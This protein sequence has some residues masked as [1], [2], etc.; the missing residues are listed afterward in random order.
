MLLSFGD[1]R[2]STLRSFH[3]AFAL[4][5]SVATPLHAQ[6]LYGPDQFGAVDL[7][8]RQSTSATS[9][10][11]TLGAKQDRFEPIA[12]FPPDDPVRVLGKAVGRLDIL[13]AEP[14]GNRGVANCTTTLIDRDKILTNYHCVP[15]LDG[16]VIEKILVR[17]GYLDFGSTTSKAFAVDV[18]PIEANKDLDYAI[19]H[20]AGDPGG[21]FGIAPLK[22]R[23]ATANERLFI[24]RHPA[25]Q[26]RRLTRAFCRADPKLAIDQTQLRHQCDTLPGSSGALIFAQRD[27][28]LVG[29]HH[30]GGLAA[31]D[32]SSFNQAIDAIALGHGS[33]EFAR[34]CCDAKSVPVVATVTPPPVPKPVS[35]EACSGGEAITVSVGGKDKC[36]KPGDSF[37]DF[38]GGPEMVMLPAGE[39]LMGSSPAEIEALGKAYPVDADHGLFKWEAPQHKVTI[40]QPLAAGRYEVTRDQ[41]EAFV[42]ATGR[43]VGDTC[44]QHV[45]S[46]WIS[47]PGSFRN[48]GFFQTGVHP[49]VCISWNDAT[50]YAAWLAKT[51]GKP[52][53][54]LTEAEWEYAA[55]AI[56]EASPQPLYPFGNN[57]T[58]LCVYGN[59]VDQTFKAKFT[60]WRWRVNDCKDEYV[61]TSPAG[62]FKPNAFGL[63]DT[64]G[65]AWEWVQD[66]FEETYDLVPDDGSARKG[67]DTTCSH[68]LRGGAWDVG[69]QALRPARR[70]NNTANNWSSGA[71]FRVARTLDN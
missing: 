69:P 37:R 35:Q 63:Y 61:F 67:S 12:E 58:T 49:A 15:G 57:A 38:D 66:C 22:V 27:N 39:F 25:G 4:I 21:A 31:G 6:I 71:G 62:S 16:A 59:G 7:V 34:L 53:R 32:V 10:I 54:L 33:A 1:Q 68:S 52:Y 64:L 40:K 65:N 19:L 2:E 60:T 30:L 46:T 56:T 13:I 23:N 43:T 28:A 45:G 26:P 44:F 17:F 29:L 3:R 50:A 55:R 41:Y 42:K 51:T 48:P 9:L 8:P 47:K 14:N 18:A 5:L 20:V 11:E 70:G 36:F 24:I